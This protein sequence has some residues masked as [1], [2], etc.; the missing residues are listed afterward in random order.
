MWLTESFGRGSVG[1]AGPNDAQHKTLS[2]DGVK[3]IQCDYHGPTVP[4]GQTVDNPS[5]KLTIS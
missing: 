1:N 4:G 3:V 2:E 5:E